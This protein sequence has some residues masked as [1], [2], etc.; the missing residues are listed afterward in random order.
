MKKP[1]RWERLW[2]KAKENET[3]KQRK[4]KVP[5]SVDG[6]AINLLRKEHAWVRRM[7]HS[8]HAIAEELELSKRGMKDLIVTKLK[9]RAQWP[10]HNA[11]S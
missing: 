7:V 10:Q 8:M 5:Y 11:S 9:E 2:W 6:L 1:D 3:R 4:G